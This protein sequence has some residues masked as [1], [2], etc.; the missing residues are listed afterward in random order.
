MS[1]AKNK[2]ARQLLAE[3]ARESWIVY[4]GTFPPRECGIATF[5]RDLVDAMDDLL[6]PAVR[7][8]VVAMNTDV[9]E[10]CHYPRE[11]ICEINQERESD[12]AAA[13]ELINNSGKVKIVNVQHEFGIFGGE[14]GIKLMHFLKALTKPVVI[15]F[16]SVLPSPNEKLHGAVRLLAE[17]VDGIIVMT[18]HSKEIL[19]GEYG[20][21][22]DKVKVIPH[23]IHSMPYSTTKLAKSLLGF[24][25]KTVLSTFGLLNKGKGLEY[26]IEALPEVVKKHPETVYVIFGVT[27]PNILKRDGESYR[28]SLIKKVY[29]LGI[30]DNVKFYNRYFPLDELL[31]FLKATDIYV[32]TSLDPNQAVSGTLS[33][34]LGAGRPVVSTPFAQAKEYITGDVGMLVG[35]RDPK[36]YADAITRL[37]ENKELRQQ[38]G[39]NAYF[40]TRNMIWPNVA[41][42]CIKVFTIYAREL[43]EICKQKSLPAVN[44]D[45]MAHIT[46]DFGIVQFAKL[47]NPDPSSGYT[48]D[49]NARALIVAGSCY[50]K[51]G[52]G[53]KIGHASKQKRDLA[54]LL[55]V[56]LNFIAF[57]SKEDGYFENYVDYDKTLNRELNQKDNLED[58]NSRALYALAFISTMDAI[59]GNIRK[60]A[61]SILE[62]K[63]EKK[64][65]FSSPRAIAFYIK[66]LYLLLKKSIKVGQIDLNSDLKNYCDRLLAHY[67]D[68]STAEWHWFERYLTYSNGVLPEAL[69][70]GYNITQNKKYYDISKKTL[71]FLLKESF[72]GETYGPIGQDGWRHQDGQ[73]NYYDQQPEEVA[74]LIYALKSFYTVTGDKSY[75][76][77]KYKVF[78]WFLGDNTLNQVIYDRTTGGCYD[79]LS[80]KNVNLNQG[81]ESTISYLLARLQID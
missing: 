21:L 16:H 13:A 17:E 27:H 65:P 2:Q 18:K 28:N 52:A 35:F 4:L 5:T 64:I 80:E 53:M 78:N 6:M 37:V 58:A 75:Q 12:Y 26:V 49:D 68:S 24:S 10:R 56:Y 34:A 50:E 9:V 32:S 29:D 76:K 79:G 74:A 48:L 38:L 11:V 41:I 67:N 36:T 39:K 23:G 19:C 81:A 3:E 57:V 44:L 14:Y 66:S 33:Y 40:K 71:E 1:K 60:K 46:D 69:I 54:A 31:Q 42:E 72:V 25:G 51:F 15:T 43:N 61:L 70:L 30:V 47:T 63:I 8:K 22:A 77:L 73:R 7:S 62:S 20:I 59:P 45:H 55:T